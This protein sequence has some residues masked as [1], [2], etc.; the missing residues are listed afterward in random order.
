[1]RESA[2]EAVK[3]FCAPQN[4]FDCAF[5]IANNVVHDFSLM[6]HDYK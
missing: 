4:M 3:Q 2:V 6:R 5:L 1:M